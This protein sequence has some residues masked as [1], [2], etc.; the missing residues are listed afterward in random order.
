[1]ES[2]SKPM[3]MFLICSQ[4]C[5]ECDTWLVSEEQVLRGSIL[6]LAWGRILSAIKAESWHKEWKGVT[7]RL[8]SR[9]HAAMYTVVILNLECVFFLQILGF[10]LLRLSVNISVLVIMRRTA[11]IFVFQ[12]QMN[13]ME[14]S[15]YVSALTSCEITEIASTLGWQ[16]EMYIVPKHSKICR[17]KL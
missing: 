6:G 16:M 4:T 9:K 5:C 1:M 2:I 17:S 8:N 13:K 15:F 3:K 11:R 10:I 14:L 7:L 12:T